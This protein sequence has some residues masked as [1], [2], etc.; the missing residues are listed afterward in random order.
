VAY[1][2]SVQFVPVEPSQL[3]SKQQKLW[4]AF[5]TAQAAFRE[6]LQQSAP[7]G[8]RIYFSEKFDKLKIGMGKTNVLENGIAQKM[9]SLTEFLKAKADQGRNASQPYLSIALGSAMGLGLLHFWGKP[10]IAV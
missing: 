10:E 8:H 9:P 7:P 6:A 4:S 1:K 2:E 5:L 3:S